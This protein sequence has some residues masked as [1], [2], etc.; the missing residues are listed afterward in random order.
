MAQVSLAGPQLGQPQWKPVA[1]QSWGRT[2]SQQVAALL[3]AAEHGRSF[4]A[5]SG[6]KLTHGHSRLK[7]CDS[8]DTGQYAEDRG[9]AATPEWGACMSIRVMTAANL[10]HL[11]WTPSDAME[12]ET[13]RFAYYW[14]PT[15][16][17]L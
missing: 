8:Q 9:Q 15:A 1:Q 16:S 4:A 7:H 14:L 5:S 2:L 10:L 12:P 11:Q 6:A 17:Q 3:D 13:V